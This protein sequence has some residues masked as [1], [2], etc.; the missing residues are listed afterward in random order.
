VI[1]NV[2][3]TGGGEELPKETLEFNYGVCEY[4]Y[5]QTHHET[6][7]GIGA[8]KRTGWSTVTNRL[9]KTNVELDSNVVEAASAPSS[10]A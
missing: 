9:L 4:I 1:T 2:G 3:I 8:P 5:K 7:A 6:G 10:D